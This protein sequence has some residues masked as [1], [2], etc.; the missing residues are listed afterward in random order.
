MKILSDKI[1]PGAIMEKWFIK[2]L[3]QLEQELADTYIEMY[4]SVPVTEV[5]NRDVWN[6][7]FDYI[8]KNTNYKTE[9][10]LENFPPIVSKIEQKTIPV[11]LP[12]QYGW[13][14]PK[15]GGG[16]SPWSSH[17][18]CTPVSSGPIMC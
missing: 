5:F 11:Q 16:N 17:C 6:H 8:V 9:T 2:D 1:R 7:V 10:S 12:V 3:R 13:M 14:C 4:K 15:C 18:P